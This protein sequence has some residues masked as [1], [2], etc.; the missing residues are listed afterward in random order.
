MFI[1]F[2]KFEN[3]FL[4]E[5]FYNILMDD[6]FCKI[7]AGEIPTNKVYETDRVIVIRDIEPKAPVHDLIIPKKHI[8]G[9]NGLEA[10]DAEIL[11]DILFAASKVAEIEGIREKGYRL[12]ANTGK[13]A[14]QLVPHLHFH[15]LGGRHLGPKIIG[16]WD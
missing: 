5:S 2:C 8:E 11:A 9:L 13:E 10:E 3:C 1:C 6:I 12:I 15:L 16:D 14:G 4:P 7:I